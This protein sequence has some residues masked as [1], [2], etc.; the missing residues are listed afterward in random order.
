MDGMTHLTE[1]LRAFTTERE[2][3]Q[4]HTPKNLAMA[5]TGEA[6]EL[7]A[8][9]QW[10]DDAAITKDLNGDLRDRLANEA[11]DVFIYLVRFADVCGIDL[12]TEGLAKVE[13]NRERYPV[14]RAR[15]VSTKYTR[16]QRD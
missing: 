2:W 14:D 11:A 5:L 9:L 13:R 16:L 10:L 15:G 12:V 8:E 7:A 3:D 4:F 6:G 1:T